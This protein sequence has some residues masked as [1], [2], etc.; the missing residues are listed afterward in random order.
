M[1][2][3]FSFFDSDSSFGLNLRLGL[4]PS[5]MKTSQ[6]KIYDIRN[7]AGFMTAFLLADIVGDNAC[8]DFGVFNLFVL[9]FV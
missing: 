2:F 8:V 3:S 7:K 4:V 9:L 5:E 6:I 1:L